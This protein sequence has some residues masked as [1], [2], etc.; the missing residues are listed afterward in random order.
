MDAIG[1]QMNAFTTKE[2]TCFYAHTLDY[3]VE[4]GFSILAD[5]LTA[6]R[7]EEEDI[8]TEKSVV[9]EEIGMS[10]D[11]PDDL[12]FEQLCAAVWRNSP[13]GMPILGI[14]FSIRIIFI[15]PYIDHKA[16]LCGNHIVQT[17]CLYSGYGHFHFS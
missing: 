15:H 10:E 8:K 17:T 4:E 3:H 5:M 11:D 12:V 7:L 1:G 16:T 13:Y 9:I 6:A 14:N 2:Y